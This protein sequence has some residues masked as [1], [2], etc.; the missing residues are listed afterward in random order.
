MC[1][2]VIVC[3]NDPFC[4]CRSGV[5]EALEWLLGAIEKNVESRAPNFV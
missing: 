2:C 5:M 3:L 1:V 4:V